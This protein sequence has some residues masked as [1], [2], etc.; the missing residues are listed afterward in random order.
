MQKVTMSLKNIF[1]LLFRF[2]SSSLI[3]GASATLSVVSN[4][5]NRKHWFL[6]FLF[7]YYTKLQSILSTR[8]L[9]FAF[10]VLFT[11]DKLIQLKRHATCSWTLRRV[12]DIFKAAVKQHLAVRELIAFSGQTWYLVAQGEIKL[13]KTKKQDNG[14]IIREEIFCDCPCL[15]T[16]KEKMEKRRNSA[17]SLTFCR[18]SGL[19]CLGLFT[20]SHAELW[21][22]FWVWVLS[23]LLLLPLVLL[24]F[25]GRPAAALRGRCRGRRWGGRGGDAG[26]RRGE[27]P[28]GLPCRTLR[29]RM[30]VGLVLGGVWLGVLSDWGVLPVPLSLQLFC[31]LQL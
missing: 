22:V 2:Y 31:F 12:P 17:C 23:L 24:L 4:I 16:E 27:G 29:R 20:F 7:N 28:V 25:G 1:I 5:C 19:V 3:K 8:F 30:N 13:K 10:K 14:F 6:Q 26:S 15:L 21:T 18:C 11:L 9:Q